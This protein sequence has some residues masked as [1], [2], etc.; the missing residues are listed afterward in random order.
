MTP[1]DGS[2][3]RLLS[4]REVA[5]APGQQRQPVVE[6]GE[7]CRGRENFDP[8]GSELNG[9]GQAIQSPADGDDS[10]RVLGAD[11]EILLDRLRA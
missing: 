11:D 10:V 7:Q 4:L 1:G 2:P 9:E 6:P 5:S 3:H 8:G